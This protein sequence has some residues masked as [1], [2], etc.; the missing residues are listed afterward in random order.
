MAD[1]LTGLVVAALAAA[2]LIALPGQADS[3]VGGVV[4]SA[5]MP[6]W[7]AWA[8][9]VLG[10]ALAANGAL[11]M[12]R[13]AGERTPTGPAEADATEGPLPGETLRGLGWAAAT[14]VVGAAHAAL[15]PVLGYLL[16]TALALPA[17][18]VIFGGRRWTALL[19]PALILPVAIYAFFRYVMTVFLPAG[20]LFG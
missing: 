2:V 9:L 5:S 10:L 3:V 15:M 13:T 11:A 17:L 18:S 19:L 16:S 6:G 7:I 8:L 20:S 1:L 12:R 4:T 14:L